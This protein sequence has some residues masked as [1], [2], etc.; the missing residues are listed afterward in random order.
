MDVRLTRYF[1]IDQWEMS[2]NYL[3]RV[4]MTYNNDEK[5]LE[6]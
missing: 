5:W 4:K 2:E 6:K 3:K 1:S